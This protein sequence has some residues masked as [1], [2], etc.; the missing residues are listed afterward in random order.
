[1]VAAEDVHWIDPSSAHI[2]ERLMGDASL[3]R[4]LWLLT[5]RPD[6]A[7]AEP[8]VPDVVGAARST[9]GDAAHEIVLTP[10]SGDDSGRLVAN[11]LEVEE[12]PQDVRQLIQERSDG[13]PY[14]VEEVIRVLIDRGL[15]ERRGDSWVATAS[16]DRLDIPDNLHGLLLARIDLLPRE[17]RHALLVASVIGR[18]FPVR[19]LERVLEP[20]SA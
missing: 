4:V 6:T 5:R 12:L 15:L 11:L 17:A 16:V 7:P 18:R 2:I 20:A 3:R 13:N 9:F 14:F 1:M 10:L 19:V 8:D